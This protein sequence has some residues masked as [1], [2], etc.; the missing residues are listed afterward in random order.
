[1]IRFVDEDTYNILYKKFSIYAN[2]KFLIALKYRDF[3]FYLRD[4]GEVF[5]MFFY[6]LLFLII[7][8]FSLIYTILTFIPILI[9]KRKVK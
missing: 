4:L 6:G 7:S 9:I 8:P 1:M 3:K 2:N 5:N